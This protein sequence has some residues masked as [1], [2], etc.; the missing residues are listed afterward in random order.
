MTTRATLDRT[1]SA[2][3][4]LVLAAQPV[5]LLLLRGDQAIQR[6]NRR[7]RDTLRIDSEVGAVVVTK[8]KGGAKVLRHRT[9]VAHGGWLLAIAPG[10]DRQP[11]HLVQDRR[12]VD[13]CDVLLLI[14]IAHAQRRAALRAGGLAGRGR[15][16]RRRASGYRTFRLATKIARGATCAAATDRVWGAHPGRG[17]ARRRLTGPAGTE[18]RR[19]GAMDAALSTVHG[20]VLWVHAAAVAAGTPGH[21]QDVAHAAAARSGSPAGAVGSSASTRANAPSRPRVS[22][23]PAHSVRAPR[24]DRVSLS[25]VMGGVR[26]GVRWRD[27]AATGQQ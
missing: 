20:V 22:S 5:D 2:G 19:P 24:A 10:R 3:Q 1:Q 14:S 23:A 18:R 21:A 26:P 6:L 4:I 25:V 27:V 13:G 7:Q 15:E 16:T 11:T 9:E 12:G 8:A 17:R